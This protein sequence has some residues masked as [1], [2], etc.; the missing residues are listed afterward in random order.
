MPGFLSLFSFRQV[1]AC[2]RTVAE[3]LVAICG[4]RFLYR[5]LLLGAV[6]PFLLF[7]SHYPFSSPQSASL[8]QAPVQ[9][10]LALAPLSLFLSCPASA[11][12]ES[13]AA[14]SKLQSL[15]CRDQLLSL[16]TLTHARI[17]SIRLTLSIFPAFSLEAFLSVSPP[18]PIVDR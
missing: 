6:F 7:Y 12:S 13:A 18:P 4:T 17:L 1:A 11:S 2:A 16:H 15:P 8:K 14:S 5:F 9:F 10:S 3:R